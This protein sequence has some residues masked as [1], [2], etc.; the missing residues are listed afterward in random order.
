MGSW[1]QG[2]GGGCT[3]MHVVK[4]TRFF[5]LPP[6]KTWYRKATI[7]QRP[8]AWRRRRTR[9]CPRTSCRSPSP[10]GTTTATPRG[11]GRDRTS[12]T[13]ARRERGSGADR[14]TSQARRWPAQ[15]RPSRSSKGKWLKKVQIR[16]SNAVNWDKLKG[17]LHFPKEEK[18]KEKIVWYA[19]CCEKKST[20]YHVIALS[21]RRWNRIKNLFF[22]AFSL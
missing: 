13:A 14:G 22:F 11:S 4:K 3:P 20:I 16:T 21:A 12:P 9:T 2:E 19:L 7:L 17:K 1:A 18:E 8:T 5:K 10:P 15:R 6:L